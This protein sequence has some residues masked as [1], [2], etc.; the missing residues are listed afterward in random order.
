MGNHEDWRN[1]L[2]IL[3]PYCFTDILPD[4]IQFDISI[5]DMMQFLASMKHSSSSP[6]N[7]IFDAQYITNRIVNIYHH[8]ANNENNTK[9]P[10]ITKGVIVLLDTARNVPKNKAKT[11]I[12]RDSSHSLTKSS[13][14]E[15][16]NN[17]S[18]SDGEEDDNNN[19][20]IDYNSIIMNEQIYESVIKDMNI[21]YND[22]II[23]YNMTKCSLLKSNMIWRSNNLKW[24]LNSMIVQALLQ[25][26]TVSKHKVLII[27][28]G[29]ILNKDIYKE[30][31]EK[32]IE[33]Y[34]YQNK[35]PFEIEVFISFMMNNY[36]IQRFILHSDR[37][38]IRQPSSC[39]G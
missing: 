3:F 12:S 22:Y 4:G 18:E 39:I 34:G 24:Q 11:Q 28:D 36:M 21:S 17:I 35:S 29:I 37:T 1:F 15:D 23:H 13:N 38:F 10:I 6:E 14:L 20:S 8:Y 5:I 19:N 27:D 9:L 31:R 16:D 33:D 32:M 25:H 2:L 7:D 30:K 26:S